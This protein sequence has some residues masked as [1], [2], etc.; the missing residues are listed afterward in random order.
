MLSLLE[1]RVQCRHTQVGE[2]QA[3]PEVELGSIYWEAPIHTRE[4]QF[5]YGLWGG[6][7]GYMC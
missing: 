2:G 4:E 5:I 6:K 3:H 1:E 7:A